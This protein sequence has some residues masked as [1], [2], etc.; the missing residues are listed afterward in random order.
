MVNKNYFKLVKSLFISNY[1]MVIL[2]NLNIMHEKC[3][4]SIDKEQLFL[5]HNDSTNC[6]HFIYNM[7]KTSELMNL[8]IKEFIM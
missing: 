6:Q 7:F 5:Y 8:M 3:L 4:K 2:F 1:K